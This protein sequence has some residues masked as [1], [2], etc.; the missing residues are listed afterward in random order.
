M[1]FPKLSDQVFNLEATAMLTILSKKC[2]KYMRANY[3]GSVNL[4][5][6]LTVSSPESAPIYKGLADGSRLCY[7]ARQSTDIPCLQ[8]FY[9]C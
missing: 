4:T 3:K 6:T 5:A 1:T 8:S 7:G 2:E 9:R